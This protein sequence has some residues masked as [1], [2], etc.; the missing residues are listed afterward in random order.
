[1]HARLQQFLSA[2]NLSQSQFADSIGVARASISHILN[3]RN[4]PGFD[5]ILNMS[6]HFPT[7]NIEWL[8]TGKGR[9]Y[10]DSA[11]PSAQQKAR[12]EDMTL[13]NEPEPDNSPAQAPDFG[14]FER[15]IPENELPKPKAELEVKP[16]L[17]PI[18][19]QRSISRI[20][21]FYDDN[22]F[23]ELK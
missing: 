22:T 4:K 9:M 5:F 7:L 15:E 2:E 1:M 20:I 10:K 13:F 19:K 6:R 12:Q 3:G 21:V 17:S 14:L 23:E 16:S 11:S 18:H 8:I